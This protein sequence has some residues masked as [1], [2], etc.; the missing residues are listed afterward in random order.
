MF[1]VKVIGTR[2]IQIDYRRTHNFT[3]QA[4]NQNIE[5]KKII[6]KT[7]KIVSY[8]LMV[9]FTQIVFQTAFK[10]WENLFTNLYF[11]RKFRSNRSINRATKTLFFPRYELKF[12]LR[13]FFFVF[14]T[15]L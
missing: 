12:E 11:S 1:E 15:M 5:K 3:P 14:E 2:T 10:K 13:K 4:V 6:K 9:N 8:K 7:R